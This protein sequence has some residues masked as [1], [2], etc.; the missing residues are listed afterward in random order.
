MGHLS[1]QQMV[2]FFMKREERSIGDDHL[3]DQIFADELTTKNAVDSVPGI[4]SMT[5]L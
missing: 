1:N 3:Y 5:P 4:I 2:I